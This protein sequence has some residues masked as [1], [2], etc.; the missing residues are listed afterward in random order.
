MKRK[1]VGLT[2]LA[3]ALSGPAVAVPDHGNDSH[4]GGTQSGGGGSQGGHGDDHGGGQSG[5]DHGGQTGNDNRGPGNGNANTQGVQRTEARL[6]L[7][8]TGVGIGAHGTA[9]LRA[10]GNQQRVKVEIEANVADGTVFTVLANGIA[11]GTITIR[12]Q[13]GE[14]EL[15]LGN[16]ATL[17]G[18]LLVSAITSIAV[19]DAAG[20]TVLQGQFA[21]INTNAPATTPAPGSVVKTQADLTPSAAAASLGASGEAEL[22]VQGAL[23]TFKVEVNANVADGTIWSVSVNGTMIG[24]LQFKLHAAEFRIESGASLPGGLTSLAGIS[25]VSIADPGGNV[26]LSGTLK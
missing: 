5:D 1:L 21:A 16:G 18:G 6:A 13:E 3:I 8:P 14:L 24:L 10:Q 20:A 4:G 7:T 12:L 22:R 9:D 2:C 25:T 15:E 23:Q 17:P 11:I 19:Q 26:L